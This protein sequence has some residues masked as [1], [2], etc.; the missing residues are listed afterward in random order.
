MTGDD[1]PPAVPAGWYAD[2]GGSGGWRYWDGVAWTWQTTSATNPQQAPSP[3]STTPPAAS[4]AVAP[5]APSAHDKRRRSRRGMWV[6]IAV[7]TAAPAVGLGLG[8]ALGGWGEVSLFA[9][10]SDADTEPAADRD[11]DRGDSSSAPQPAERRDAPADTPAQQPAEQDE[12]AAVSATDLEDAFAGY[13]RSLDSGDIDR[14]YAHISPSLRQQDGWSHERFK[15]FREEAI[16]GSRVVRIDDVR[17]ASE[18]VEATVD[19][20]LPDGAV[21]RE[22]VRTRFVRGADGDLLLDEYEVMDVE[23]LS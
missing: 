6:V 7:L 18:R 9:G 4:G 2:P 16:T 21:S 11:V 10:E 15:T 22:A 14:A 20:D 3:I 1:R 5:G 19:F 12:S 8:F 13:I 23:R 17:A